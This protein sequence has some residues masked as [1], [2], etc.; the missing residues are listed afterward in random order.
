MLALVGC[1][2][3]T[4]GRLGSSSELPKELQEK[5]E[6][7]DVSE[8]ART[9]APVPTPAP[10]AAKKKTKPARGSKKRVPIA[11][12]AVD[13]VAPVASTTPPP[14]AYP[15]RRPAKDPVWIGEKMVFDISYFGMSAGDFTLEALPL[16]AINERKVYHIKGSAVSSKVF[17]LFYRLNDT[18]ETF[19]DYDGLFSHRFH[20]VLDETKQSRD[21]LE[22]YDQEKKQTFYWNRWNH[23]ERGYT[24]TKEYQ[25]IE[26]FAQDSLSAMYFL[27]FAPLP[28]GAVFTVPVVS[29]GKGWEAQVTVVRRE[30]MRTPMGKVRCVVV[31]P[32]TKYQG[33]LKKQG[34]SFLWLTDDDR[35]VVVRLEA[36]VR[37]GTVIAN[38]KGFEPGTAP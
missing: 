21:S 11:D 28:D 25:P 6:V 30:M 26:Q 10:A 13:E 3:G 1:A 24:E 33:V 22:L 37:I 35:R 38:L 27:R 14:I 7:T 16:K 31:K 23:K 36:K 34:D 17:S 8:L 15:S 32:E 5:F 2:G 29:E 18:V 20:I 19:I 9:A 12:L 4:L